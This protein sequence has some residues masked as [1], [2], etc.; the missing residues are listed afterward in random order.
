[1]GA[2]LGRWRGRLGL[3]LCLSLLP[4]AA[5]AQAPAPDSPPEP[6]GNAP[7]DAVKFLAGGALAFVTH[8]GGHLLLDVAFDGHARF[9]RV[10]FG[11]V[12]FFA[13]AHRPDLSPR[14]EFMVSSAGFWTQEATSEWLLTTHPDLRHEHAPVA[15]GV[16]AFDVLTSVGYG[17][18]AFAEAG[19]FERDTRGMAAAIGVNERAIGAMVIAPAVFDAYRYF[20]PRERWAAWASRA[21]KM[22]RVLLVLK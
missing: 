6:Q 10:H 18:V 15:K 13:I 1:L 21:A 7:V 9:E 19:P 17:L 20:R 12:P 4:I 8:E 14:R 3:A 11:A 22:G 16:L 2:V 5:G